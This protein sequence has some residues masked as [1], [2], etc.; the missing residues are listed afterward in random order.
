M[1]SFWH[2]VGV[3]EIISC[4]SLEIRIVGNETDLYIYIQINIGEQVGT[5][6]GTSCALLLLLH[7]Q[8]V[9]SNLGCVALAVT[10]TGC[11]LLLPTSF[12]SLASYTDLDL[13]LPRNIKPSRYPNRPLGKY[14]DTH[15]LLG[16]IYRHSSGAEVILKRPLGKYTPSTHVT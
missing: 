5:V 8:I 12:L 11:E 1:L 13:Y 4:L 6:T 3:H 14:T 7:A 2:G 9:H 16:L 10:C 15:T